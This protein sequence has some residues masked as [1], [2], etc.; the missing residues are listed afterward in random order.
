MSLKFASEVER[1]QSTPPLSSPSFHSSWRLNFLDSCSVTGDTFITSLVS[2]FFSFAI[3]SFWNFSTD[4]QSC[5]GT[6]LRDPKWHYILLL[7]TCFFACRRHFGTSSNITYHLSDKWLLFTF[8]LCCRGQADAR[9]IDL[10][11]ELLTI[12]GSTLVLLALRLILQSWQAVLYIYEI[13]THYMGWVSDSQ[14]ISHSQHLAATTGLLL[15]DS[16]TENESFSELQ[17]K[18]KSVQG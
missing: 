3:S 17:M 1:T 16:V 9:A 7:K 15:K 2:V 10:R 4:V 13:R 8:I 12:L 5:Y 18:P 14:M 11:R 6:G